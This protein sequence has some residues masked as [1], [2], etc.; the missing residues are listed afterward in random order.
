MRRLYITPKIGSGTREDM[1]RAAYMREAWQ[2]DK[3]LY[4]NAEYVGNQGVI[5]DYALVLADFSDEAHAQLA[6]NN[7]VFQFPE[8]E[9]LDTVIPF[10]D[11]QRLEL[12]LSTLGVKVILTLTTRTYAELARYLNGDMQFGQ[13]ATANG[14][15]ELKGAKEFSQWDVSEKDKLAAIFAQKGISN[16]NLSDTATPDDLRKAVA[17]ASADMDFP[18]IK[19]FG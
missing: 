17:E 11:A 6:K 12:L 7:D 2:T 19:G 15:T 8:L 9:K 5:G 16:S 18:L 1:F 13:L 14:L 10:A 3:K 4:P